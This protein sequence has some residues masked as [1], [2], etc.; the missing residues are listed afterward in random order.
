MI[1]SQ[2]VQDSNIAEVHVQ[3]PIDAKDY[4]AM[5][6]TIERMLRDYDQISLLVTVESLGGVTP[7][8]VWEDMKMAKYIDRFERMAVVTDKDWMENVTEVAD[9]M[10]GLEL[11]HFEL[12]ERE[13]AL[14]WLKS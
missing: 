11:H 12:G 8:A 13:A 7:K 3:G 2:Q 6:P 10:P 9:V 5:L 1:S 14:Q 4:E